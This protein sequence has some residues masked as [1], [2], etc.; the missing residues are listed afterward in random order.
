MLDAVVFAMKK[1]GVGHV[2]LYISETGWPNNSDVEQ[3]GGNP[4]NAATYNRN[5][6]KR[7]TSKPPIGTPTRPGEALPAF[8]FS[9][10]NENQKPGPG[11]ER[12][13]GIF[14]PNS[15][16]VYPFDLSGKTP[17]SSYP[18]IPKGSNNVPY[19]GQVWCIVAI[20][21]NM[22]ELGLAM[23]Y[24]CSQ[25]N[26]TCDAIQPG[27]ECFSP[28]QLVSHA[29]YAFSSYWARFRSQGGTCLF[30]GLAVETTNDPSK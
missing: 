22:T 17:I 4:H 11:T 20:D 16:N 24:A 15:T 14:Y 3:I 9:L 28:N 19:K 25:G 13:W 18:S 8:I 10:Y 7:L 12:H 23:S 2:K 21:A 5:L 6:V 30:N 27:K 1:L 26:G 29:S